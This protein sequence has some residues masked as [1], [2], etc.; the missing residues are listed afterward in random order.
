MCGLHLDLGSGG[1]DGTDFQI[2]HSIPI[3]F[4]ERYGQHD[5]VHEDRRKQREE[6]QFDAGISPG[7]CLLLRQTEAAI[8]CHRCWNLPICLDERG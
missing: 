2:L 5:F 8:L 1:K 3:C 4:D 6:E 7:R